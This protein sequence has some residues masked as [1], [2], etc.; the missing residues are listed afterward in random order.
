VINLGR[1]NATAA[2]P[3]SPEIASE[4]S[5]RSDGS[6]SLG[7]NAKTAQRQRLAMYG[8]IS[9]LAVGCMYWIMQPNDAE[10]ARQTAADGSKTVKIA[11]DDIVN[12]NVS[13]K[14]WMSVSQGQMDS[15]QKAIQTLQGDSAKL[16]ELQKRIDSF[17]LKTPASRATARRCLALTK[18]KQRP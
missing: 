14:E 1:R 17:R 12:K 13:D 15:Q 5:L 9:L 6:L 2:A 18:G 7:N 11:T 3:P 10:K 4:E 16:D 8:G